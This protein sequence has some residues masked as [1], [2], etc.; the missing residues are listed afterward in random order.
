M[1]PPAPPAPGRDPGGD[2]GLAGERTRLAWTRT[3]IAFTA[4]GA[5]VLKTRLAEGVVIMA[6][7]GVTWLLGRFFHDP[8]RGRRQ[9]AR[10]LAITAT[11]V[12][13]A[14]VALVISF[15]GRPATIRP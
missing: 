5:A 7:G 3:T 9:E 14:A 6:L 15:L 13:A 8:A 4:L 2:P 1:A 10:L 12:A 11:V